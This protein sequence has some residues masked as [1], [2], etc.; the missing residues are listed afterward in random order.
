MIDDEL[1]M[2]CAGVEVSLQSPGGKSC[3]SGEK[4]VKPK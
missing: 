1:Y 4:E 3:K 2:K